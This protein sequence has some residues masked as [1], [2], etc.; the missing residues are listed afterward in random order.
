MLSRR[1]RDKPIEISQGSL[2][3]LRVADPQ[4][5]GGGVGV[6][7]AKRGTLLGFLYQRHLEI[8]DQ[9]TGHT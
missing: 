5:G 4:V 3:S 7:T 6:G 9:V 8:G 2:G 1:M